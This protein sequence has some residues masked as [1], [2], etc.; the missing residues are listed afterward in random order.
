MD[1][2]LG[3]WSIS[4]L[5]IFHRL[6]EHDVSDKNGFVDIYDPIISRLADTV[7]RFALHDSLL[8]DKLISRQK[9]I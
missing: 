4:V 8:C 6:D 7:H 3:H 2:F 9:V 1:I 5:S